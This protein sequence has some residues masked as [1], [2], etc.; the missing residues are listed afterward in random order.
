[1]EYETYFQRFREGI[2]GIEQMFQSPYGEKKLIYLDWT[3]SGRLYKPIEEKMLN[4]FGPFVANTHTESN[5]TGSCMTKAYH[6]AKNI[7][8]EHVNANERDILLF[9]GTGMTG[10]VTKFQRLLKLKEKKSVVFI[11]HMEH[12]SNQISWLESGCKLV[13]I[14][15]DQKGNVS[16]EK[17][18]EKL[19]EYKDYPIKI[20]AFTAASNVSGRKVNYHALAKII[21]EYNGICMVD[22]SAI[23]PYEKINMHPDCEDEKLDAI[24]FSPHKFLGGPGTSGVLLF[25]SNLYKNEV[26]DRPGGGTVLW[27]NPW[28][29]RRY[30]ENIEEREDGGTPGF[31]QA[32][33]T[34]LAI[35]LKEEMD[36]EQIV[37]REKELTHYLLSEMK[38]IKNVVILDDMKKEQIA[39]V[40][41]YIKNLHFDLIVSLLSDKFGIQ[42]RGGCSCAGTYGHYLL[43]IDQEYSKK[44]TDEIDKGNR[45]V[46]PGW[47]RVSLHPTTVKS[48]IDLFVHALKDIIGNQKIYKK[49]YLYS[50]EQNKF[51][52]KEI[53]EQDITNWFH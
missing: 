33:R 21:H 14:P 12:H 18:M 50:K 30:I 8:K 16:E 6:E 23:A 4:L 28:E 53:N 17:L 34:A 22:F 41:F 13:I 46:K 27:T 31:L 15:P 3:A 40:S 43:N 26:P 32:I 52:H 49:D 7:I 25:D 11:T 5:V 42:V 35:R 51:I 47:V 20:G 44:I 2:V 38:K 24:A 37:K 39:T 36:V 1:M 29:G 45:E 48:E 10:A 9:E 19:N